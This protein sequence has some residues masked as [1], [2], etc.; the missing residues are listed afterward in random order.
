MSA[1]KSQ[2]DLLRD[3]INLKLD[4]KYD[5]SSSSNITADIKSFCVQKKQN[6][7]SVRPSYNRILNQC[8]KN[9]NISLDTLGRKTRKPKFNKSLQSKIEPSPVG[10]ITPTKTGKDEKGVV[11]TKTIQYYD[12][13]GRPIITKPVHDWE[14]F[15]AEGVGATLNA[16]FIMVRI[17]YPELEALTDEEKKSLGRMWL[18]AFQR[19]LSENWAYIGIP[20]LATM[21]MM[22]PKIAAARRVHKE[23]KI[24]KKP[25][26][27]KAAKDEKLRK[28]VKAEIIC[29]WCKKKENSWSD[30]KYHKRACIKKPRGLSA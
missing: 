13:E 28:E 6:E 20:F 30:L 23:G 24:E 14:N 29:E 2:A 27:I 4:Q 7:K 26:N 21:G 25:E 8:L 17:T 3:W 9:R 19:Y 5:Y 18:P 11:T 1:N 22:L 16:F 10:E 12:K 15:D